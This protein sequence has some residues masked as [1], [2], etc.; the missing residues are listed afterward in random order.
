[1]RYHI[2]TIPVW[3][4]FK[5][6]S[7]CPLCDLE[8][9][10]EQ[11]YLEAFLG[12]T[13][14][15]P[16]VR[17]EV[18]EKGFCQDHFAEMITMK[19]RLGLALMTHT[20][21]MDTIQKLTPPAQAKKGLFAKKKPETAEGGGETCILCERLA[22]TMDRYLYTVLHLWK[23]DQDFKAVLEA[24]KG[25]CLPHYQRLTRMAGQALG[26]KR[27]QAFAEMLHTLE[28]ENLRRIEKE[29]KWFTLKFDYRNQEK[30]WGNSRDSLERVINKLRG[31]CV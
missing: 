19:N 21:L 11:A 7:E 6:D 5:A 20:H 29:L 16:D 1:M 2:D 25:F 18:N 3:D 30:P 26:A 27:A 17:V 13:V 12:A 24:S 8:K 22:C 10:N 15:E 23:T 31:K 4:A 28:H 14:M 9:S